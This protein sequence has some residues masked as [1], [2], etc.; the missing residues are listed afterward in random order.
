VDPRNGLDWC[1]K[2]PPPQQGCPVL[3]RKKQT[4]RFWNWIFFLPEVKGWRVVGWGLCEFLECEVD[5]AINIFLSVMYRS[6][7]RFE[8][9]ANGEI[10]GKYVVGLEEEIHCRSRENE[11]TWG[12]VL[13][14]KTSVALVGV[15]T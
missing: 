14:E 10:Q 13:F 9:P 5:E 11:W 1:R 8:V 6:G 12:G 7:L 3:K 15:I 4:Q 2:S